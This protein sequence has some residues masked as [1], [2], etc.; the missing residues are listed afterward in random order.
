M[1]KKKP[2][3]KERKREEKR[4]REEEK[5]PSRYQLQ[6]SF[7]IISGNVIGIHPRMQNVTLLEKS[8]VFSIKF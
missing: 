6:R 8:A 7:N 2:F 1:K 3:K 5:L 4:K